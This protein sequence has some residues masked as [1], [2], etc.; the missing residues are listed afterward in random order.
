MVPS[1]CVQVLPPRL[2]QKHSAGWHAGRDG[3]AS[4]GGGEG[5][6]APPEAASPQKFRSLDNPSF[7]LITPPPP[8]IFR[9]LD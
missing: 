8:V 7:G 2:T 9:D 4:G 5:V 3:V 6:A 1:A